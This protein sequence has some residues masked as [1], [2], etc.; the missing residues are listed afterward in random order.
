MPHVIEPVDPKL[1]VEANEL[2]AKERGRGDPT[3]TIVMNFADKHSSDELLALTYRL[4]ALAK[5][6]VGGHGPAWVLDV[7]GKKYKLVNEAMFRAAARAPLSIDEDQLIS[8]LSFDVDAFLK[9]ALEES[10]TDGRA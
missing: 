5:L 6:I 4:Q 3:V 7:K 9:L 2:L 1:M 8:E 10:D